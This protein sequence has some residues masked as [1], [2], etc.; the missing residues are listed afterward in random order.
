LIS[1]QVSESVL[2]DK[3]EKFCEGCEIIKL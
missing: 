3:K 1:A 2:I